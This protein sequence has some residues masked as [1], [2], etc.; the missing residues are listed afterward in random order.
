MPGH[1]SALTEGMRREHSDSVTSGDSRLG[2]GTMS[3]KTTFRVDVSSKL[4]VQ[5]LFRHRDVVTV[6]RCGTLT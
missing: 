3:K 6:Q 1:L 5:A 4:G 2:W